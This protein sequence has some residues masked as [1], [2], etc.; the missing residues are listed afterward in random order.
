VP[1][2]GPDGR[3]QPVKDPEELEQRRADIEQILRARG[4]I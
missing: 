4:I 1:R 3:F 2:S